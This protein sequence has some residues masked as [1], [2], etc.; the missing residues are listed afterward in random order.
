MNLFDAKQRNHAQTLCESFKNDYIPSIN[1]SLKEFLKFSF[2]SVDD[3]VTSLNMVIRSF[4][5]NFSVHRTKPW[6]SK[7]L[8][9]YFLQCHTRTHKKVKE[10]DGDPCKWS[11]TLQ[12]DDGK[13]AKFVKIDS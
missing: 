2:S 7:G 5:S 8:K 11:A 13:V 4:I 1:K 3:A 10:S 6:V 9:C 12:Y